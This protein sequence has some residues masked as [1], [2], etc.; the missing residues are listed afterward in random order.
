MDHANSK[1]IHLT[2]ADFRSQ[3]A[4]GFTF[5][6]FWA[7]WCTPCKMIAPFLEELA[8][9]WDGK[10]KVAKFN[11]D[12]NPTITA[13]FGVRSIPTL[14]LF[15]DGQQIDFAVGAMPKEMM[16]EFV[17]KHLNDGA[18]ADPAAT[19]AP[20]DNSTPQV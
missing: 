18:P 6:E 11:V 7:D 14:F 13:E 17:T 4:T 1:V 16:I 19:P 12:E 15:K 2:D 10:V 3:L 5:V 20:T 9:E 8:V